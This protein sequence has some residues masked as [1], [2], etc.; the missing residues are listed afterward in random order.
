MKRK[1]KKL[2][3]GFVCGMVICTNIGLEQVVWAQEIENVSELE[4]TE[5][6]E[7]VDVD[8][9]SDMGNDAD[10]IKEHAEINEELVAEGDSETATYTL[11]YSEKNDGTATIT[12]YEGTVSGELRIPEN[13]DGY[14]VTK[15]G[16]HA[17]EDCYRITKVVIPSSVTEIGDEAFYGCSGLTNMSIPSSVIHIGSSAF[18]RC[19]GLTSVIISSGVTS[20]G[21]NAFAFCDSLTSVI[22]PSSVTSMG[23]N[24]FGS[25]SG[26]KSAG[27]TGSGCDYE[28]GWEKAIPACAFF[29]CS[30]L[31]SLTIPSDVTTIGPNAVSGC[32]GLKSAGPIG[33]NYDYEFG[34]EEAIPSHAFS[35]C[36]GLVSVNIPSSVTSIGSSAFFGCSGLASVDIP[37]GAISIGSSAFYGC[38]GLTSINIPSGVTSIGSS[39]FEDCDDLSSVL[40]FNSACGIFDSPLTIPENITIFGYANSTARTYAETYGRIFVSL[41]SVENDVIPIVLAAS[42]E[43][44]EYEVGDV[45]NVDDITVT[46]RYTDGTTKTVTGFITNASDI[47]MSIAGKTILLITYQEGNV[48]LKAKVGI[49]VKEASGVIEPTHILKYNVKDDGTITI[50]GYEW[51]D[52]EDLVITEKVDGYTVTGIGNSAFYEALLTSVIIPPSVTSIDS[53]AFYYCTKLTKIRIPSSV[54]SIGSEAFYGCN[55]LTSAGP[56]GG[57]YD[58]EFGW[59]RDIPDDA[60][61]YCSGLTNV[62]IPPSVTSIGARA[63]CGCSGLTS[64][65]IPP[66]VASIGARAFE[67][68]DGLTS[69]SVPSGVT[70]IRSSAFKDCSSLSSIQILNPY[71]QIEGPDETIPDNTIIYGYTN[72]TAESYAKEYNKKFI[73]I[74]TAE[75]DAV[76]TA[77]TASKEKTEYKIGETL[78]VEDITATVS[79]TDGT[80]KTV[81]GFTTNISE[82]DMSVAGKKILVVTYREGDVELKSNIEINVKEASEIVEPKFYTVTFDVNGG[83][84]LNDTSKTVEAGKTLDLLPEVKRDG[85]LFTGWYKEAECKNKWDFDNDIVEDNITLYAGWES[86]GDVLPG[87]VPTDGEI[88]E[89]KIWTSFVEDAVYTGKAIKPE[90][91]I[92]WGKERLDEGIDYT[93]KYKNNTQANDASNLNKAPRMEINYKKHFPDTKPETI[94]FKINPVNLDDVTA[95]DLTIALNQKVQK[96]VPTVT[97]CGKKLS[98]GKD[99]DISYPDEGTPGAYQEKGAYDILLTAGKSGNFTGS[100]TVSLTI[101]DLIPVSKVF[102]KI[103][104]QPYDKGNPV[105]PEPKITYKGT[106]LEKDGDYTI[107]YENNTEIGTATAIVTGIGKYEGTKKVTFKITGTSVKKAAVTGLTKTEYNGFTQ[108]PDKLAVTLDGKLLKQGEDYNVSFSKNRNAGKATV[109]ISGM[110]AYTGTVRKIF[111]ITSYDLKQDESKKENRLVKGLEDDITVSLSDYQKGVCKPEPTLTFHGRVLKKGRDYTISYKNNKKAAIATDTKAPTIVIKGKGNFKGTIQKA[112][113]ITE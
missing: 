26:L 76:P 33:G 2:I 68:C 70:K 100:K 28:F 78:N 29:G 73:S 50:T 110:G 107:T 9:V 109:V 25:C 103:K 92:Y 7:A 24:V 101:T 15:I 62:N 23:Y 67:G 88:P 40:I 108:I 56:I 46:A 43:K 53:Y 82:I 84:G 36:S 113:T 80:T 79:Y 60:F 69:V 10:E 71:C 41:E 83:T 44:T 11:K 95:D 49:S 102:V 35:N 99:F 20:I 74:G 91:H 6:T 59:G 42:K 75:K 87:D 86:L 106:P 48:I 51:T 1:W 22:I 72:S 81:A 93:L 64:V 31:T 37:S 96:K 85:Y 94:Y 98:K 39:I 55:G 12:G 47:D 13:I 21:E 4:E 89:G 45:I 105:K 5:E 63:F 38:S 14:S 57:G 61:S 54:T 112:F 77:L 97:W 111:R 18:Y 58:Y 90:V 30:E 104:S 65:S 66:A 17:F 34:W 52:S 19:V 3:A 32:R 16:I 27:P 8:E